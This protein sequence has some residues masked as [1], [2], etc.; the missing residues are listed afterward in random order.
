MLHQS[1]LQANPSLQRQFRAELLLGAIFNSPSTSLST[2]QEIT[3]VT[4]ATTSQ[5][6]PTPFEVSRDNDEQVQSA[7]TSIVSYLLHSVGVILVAHDFQYHIQS[8]GF[9]R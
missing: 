1:L 7:E 5:L 6:S 4:T 8:A 2:E 3:L 9:D